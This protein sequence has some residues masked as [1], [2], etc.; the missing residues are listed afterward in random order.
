MNLE[1][2]DVLYGQIAVFRAAMTDPFNDWTSAHVAQGFSWR[3]GSVSFAT[4][5]ESGP[6]HVEVIR[7][8]PVG[9]T[10]PA[11][12]IIVVPFDV[13]LSGDIEVAT[14]GEARPL[15]VEP[16]VYRL[17][18]EHGLTDLGAM[19][20]RLSFERPAPGQRVD[21]LVVRADERLS[22]SDPLVMRAEPA[23]P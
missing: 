23:A 12:R 5:S 2:M 14:I 22:P 13:G 1:P 20:V 16:G 21:A 7:E 11:S 3:P 8:R 17:W 18:F 15:K 4:L 10:S 19:W 6:I 9:L